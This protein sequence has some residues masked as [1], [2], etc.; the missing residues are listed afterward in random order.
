MDLTNVSFR[1]IGMHILLL[2]STVL[3]AQ[4]SSKIEATTWTYDPARD[5]GFN[6][7]TYES[8]T[9]KKVVNFVKQNLPFRMMRPVGYTTNT[10]KY[11]LII[12]LHG[13]G[14]SGTDNNFQLK[15]GGREHQQAIQS[16]KFDGFAVF[17]Q[18]PYGAWTNA[19][20]YSANNGQ[21]S[22]ALSLVFDLVDSLVNKYNIDPNRI[23]IHG[24]SSGGTGVWASIYNRPELFAAAL[25]MSA[26]SD[27]TQVSKVC[28]TPIWLFQ[29]ADDTNP[30]AAIS[31]SMISALK[32]AGCLDPTVTKYSEYPGVQHFSW[33]PAYQEPDFFPFMLRQDRR[34]IRIL[35]LN[36]FPQG[37]SVSLGV[38]SGMG[39]Y[40]WYKDGVLIDGANTHILSG[41]NQAGYYKARFKR[42]TN[43]TWILSNEVYIYGN[44]GSNIP[45]SVQITTPSNL[46]NYISPAS[47]SILA[48][49]TDA[50]GTVAKV[51]FYNGTALLGSDL[52]AP[53]QYTWS[54]VAVGAYNIIVKATDNEGA[55]SFDTAAISVSAATNVAPTVA[56]TAP[57][58]NSSFTAPA[59]FTLSATASDVD[60]TVTRV[61]FY[62]N[63]TLIGSDQSAP[64]VFPYTNLA[65]GTYSFTA[66]ATD[67]I[68]A[69]ALSAAITV[70]VSSQPVNQAP[71]VSI[72]APANNSSFVAPA[73]ISISANAADA[74]G[75]VSQVQFY[76]GTTLL[77]SDLSAPFQY[78]WN[79]VAAGTYQ[80]KAIATD[81]KGAQTTSGIVTVIVTPIINPTDNIIASSTCLVN[82][83]TIAL[84]VNNGLKT[85]ATAYSWWFTASG[86]ISVVAGQSYKANLTPTNTSTGQVCVGI[87]YSASPWYTQVCRTFS[88]CNARI[89]LDQEE[90]A[91][92]EVLYASDDQSISLWVNKD[93]SR[94][95]ILRMDGVCV[96]SYK[97][98][99]IGVYE[100]LLPTAGGM[101]LL[102][103]SYSDNSSEVKK[104]KK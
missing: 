47:V 92:M 52:T 9:Y 93:L 73:S 24:L 71:S 29:G 98:L 6:T 46:A 48:S 26:P 54:P 49:A 64:F 57:A 28:T 101:Y 51:E 55:T 61:D 80:I 83:Q 13:R 96:G 85:N 22:T 41:V 17:P 14:E 103:A 7:S 53:Y 97:N 39:T 10:A 65:V 63:G 19:P 18:E 74:D 95:D 100:N 27:L 81:D 77:G 75:T 16:K 34:T 3:F 91:P 8:Y 66:R 60:G 68:G 82:N 35:G 76:D 87:N 33:V 94:L 88:V 20:T 50:N 11:P 37:G 43:Q 59:T 40:E 99:S 25:P 69:M 4:N 21:P 86:T 62:N 104:I 102:R 90:A 42:S 5:P 70:T 89:G 45:P 15:W 56:I 38:V 1:A 32:S 58:N 78:T 79:N 72:S 84:E 36:P 12:M 67:N 23:Y 30:I 44:D 2:F 31:R